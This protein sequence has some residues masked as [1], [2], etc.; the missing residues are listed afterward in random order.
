MSP[1]FLSEK[2][3]K[4]LSLIKTSYKGKSAEGEHVALHMHRMHIRYAF[5]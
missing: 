2:F 4:V 5:C 3:L 1:S